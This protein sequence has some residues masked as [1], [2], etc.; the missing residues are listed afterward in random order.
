MEIKIQ[1]EAGE[2]FNVKNVENEVSNLV[3]STLY[4]IETDAKRNC[5]VDTGRLRGSITTNITGKMSGECGTNVEYAEDVEYGTRPHTIRPK[6]KQALH[7]KEG[8][9]DI[10]AK[11][12]HH[13]GTK[14][15]PFFEPAVKKNEDKLD[16]DLDKLIERISK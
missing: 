7:W 12:V 6:D 1:V 5:S 9:T 14:A 16:K 4:G 13:P 2:L 10:F 15:K 3:K 11:E 8:N